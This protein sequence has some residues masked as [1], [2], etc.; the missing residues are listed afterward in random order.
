MN[1]ISNNSKSL[2]MSF[3]SVAQS[4][5]SLYVGLDRIMDSGVAVDRANLMM[6]RSAEKVH[7]AQNRLTAAISKFGANSENAIEAGKDLALAQEGLEVSSERARMSVDNQRNMILQYAVSVIPTAI[8]AIANLSTALQTMGITATISLG[9]IG[10][11]LTGISLLVAAISYMASHWNAVMHDMSADVARL[12]AESDGLVATSDRLI[13]KFNEG[14]TATNKLASAYLEWYDLVK[15]TNEEFVKTLGDVTEEYNI[16]QAKSSEAFQKMAMEYQK[17]FSAG[18]LELATGY[19]F[20]I[21]KKFELTLSDAKNL[22]DD[23]LTS[24]TTG[25]AATPLEFPGLDETLKKLQDLTGGATDAF[26]NLSDAAKEYLTGQTQ[27]T[28]G[29]FKDCATDKMAALKK[30][31]ET[32]DILEAIKIASGKFETAVTVTVQ[33][34]KPQTHWQ[35]FAE[36]GIVR[37]P[38]LTMIG[39]SGPEAVIPLNEGGGLGNNITIN[40][41]VQGSVDRRTAE[42]AASLIERRLKNVLVENSSVGGSSTHKRIRFGS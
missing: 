24:V 8:S 22:V 3:N 5:V 17:A 14:A 21:S 42:Y 34:P 11:L 25:I 2:L 36:G 38:T 37:E 9:P 29:K 7:D 35:A 16:V 19:L 31:L 33:P 23:F 6:A 1:N 15:G 40:L 13:R 18:N 32:M 10:A 4:A 20:S 27:D 12:K 28:V 39:E 26:S 30:K 41:T